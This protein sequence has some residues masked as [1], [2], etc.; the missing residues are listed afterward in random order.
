MQ[1]LLLKLLLIW[2]YNIIKV[3]KRTTYQHAK[4]R[5]SQHANAQI[6]Q[7]ATQT[8]EAQSCTKRGTKDRKK[9]NKK[10][11]LSKHQKQHFQPTTSWL[12]GENLF[13]YK[14]L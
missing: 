10:E 13:L 9:I 2:H 7:F 14:V 4:E 8:S 6:C 1:D 11:Q 5:T 12:I 3:Y